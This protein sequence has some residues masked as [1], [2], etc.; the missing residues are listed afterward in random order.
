MTLYYSQSG[1]TLEIIAKHFRTATSRI[2]NPTQA[3]LG[4]F[5]AAGI[6]LFVPDAQ[7]YAPYRQPVLADSLVVYGRNAKNVDVL[8]ISSRA[9]GYRI[10]RG[11]NQSRR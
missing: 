4:G 3:A 10:P 8:G 1:D 9:G 7:F 2:Q 11:R 5:L 6:P